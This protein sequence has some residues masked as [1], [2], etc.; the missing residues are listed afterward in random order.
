[1]VTY[2]CKLQ[3]PFLKWVGGKTQIIDKIME[4]FPKRIKNYHEIFLGGGSIL[5]GLLTLQKKKIITI[6]GSIYAYDIN[7]KLINV[8]RHIQSNKQLLFEQISK[9]LSIYNELEGNIVNRKPKSIKEA[10]TSKESYYYWM[11]H[12]FNNINKNSVECSAL[13]MIINKTCFRGLY[14]EGPNGF[15]V[16]FGHYKKTPSIITFE[17]LTYISDLIKDVNFIH[18]EFKESMRNILEGDFVYLDPPYAP[19]DEKSFVN[20]TKKGFDLNSHKLLF[21]I[22]KLLPKN[23]CKFVLSNAKVEMVI[24]E[25][26]NF[27][28]EDV[29]ARRAINSK[30][31]ESKTMEVIIF[32]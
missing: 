28:I 32:N 6:E 9:H 22:I 5:F 20:Y 24:N 8:Y 27:N 23:K 7:Q 17:D 30:N 26:S 3:K 18:A 25:F 4:K 10:L 2:N 13:F 19:E 29:I 15:N 11:R 31:P 21:K 16:P 1:M 14:R 12:L